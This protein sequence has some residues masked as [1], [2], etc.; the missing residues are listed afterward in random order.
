MLELLDEDY[1]DNNDTIIYDIF[2]QAFNAKT[3]E[4]GVKGCDFSFNDLLDIFDKMPRY[5]KL[6]A[7]S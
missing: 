1:F 4:L 6:I 3:E 2:M 7:F 5:A